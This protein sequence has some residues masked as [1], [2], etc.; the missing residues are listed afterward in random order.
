MIDLNVA[1]P[2]EEV[3]VSAVSEP[4]LSPNPGA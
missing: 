4:R 1:L 3:E 2:F